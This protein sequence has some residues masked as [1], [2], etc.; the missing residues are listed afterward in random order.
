MSIK[1]GWH[2]LVN[3][4]MMAGKTETYYIRAR[5][6][7]EKQEQI[8]L[9]QL[10]KTLIPWVT[11]LSMGS[12]AWTPPSLVLL[13]T[14]TP[15]CWFHSF[16]PAFKQNKVKWAGRRK[17]RFIDSF[18]RNVSSSCRSFLGESTVC[19]G[20]W[21]SGWPRSSQHLSLA[22]EALLLLGNTPSHFSK[23]SLLLFMNVCLYLG[24]N[25]TCISEY[26]NSCELPYFQ[27]FKQQTQLSSVLDTISI[28]L[29]HLLGCFSK[30]TFLLE[31]KV[32]KSMVSAME[33]RELLT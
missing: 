10:N 32:V 8:R 1:H 9:Q 14:L 18:Q 3:M 12:T 21:G 20:Q 7:N 30:V 25:Y 16:F 29:T 4:E 22:D 11:M 19:V 31:D 27:M 15:P 23:L 17:Q 28:F 5:M 24:Y 26:F 13:P 2:L 33:S 6:W